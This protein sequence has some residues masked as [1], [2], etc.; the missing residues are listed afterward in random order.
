MCVFQVL[1][2]AEEVRGSL[3]VCPDRSIR[4][5]LDPVLF[6]PFVRAYSNYGLATLGSDFY[7]SWWGTHGVF[8]DRI[9]PYN[10]IAT[11]R[12]PT[13]YYGAPPKARNAQ[14]GQLLAYRG[15]AVLVLLPFGRILDTQSR[16][17]VPAQANS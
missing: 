13:S 14:D 5:L 10:R 15:Y 17:I 8:F 7:P 16:T 1:F 2:D 3:L 9:A 12:V 6:L 4:L 11:E